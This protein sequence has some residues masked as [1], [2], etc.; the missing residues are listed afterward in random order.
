MKT[1]AMTKPDEKKAVSVAVIKF[2]ED[3]ELQ[4]SLSSCN[5]VTARKIDA[6]PMLL[7]KQ[8]MALRAKERQ[9]AVSTTKEMSNAR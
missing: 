1:S 9:K 6:L 8:L 4:V 2:M 5:G 3:G 7:Y